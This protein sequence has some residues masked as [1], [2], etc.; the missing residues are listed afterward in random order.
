MFEVPK[1]TGSWE[2]PEDMRA[3]INRHPAMV[4]WWLGQNPLAVHRGQPQQM[5]RALMMMEALHRTTHSQGA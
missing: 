3:F 5:V 1:Q 2:I 4:E